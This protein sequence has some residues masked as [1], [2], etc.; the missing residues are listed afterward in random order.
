[1]ELTIAGLVAQGRSNREIAAELLLSGPTVQSYVSK[2]LVKLDARTRVDIAREALLHTESSN[3][4][5]PTP[6]A[7][8]PDD[9]HEFG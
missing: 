4:R 3:G 6:P 1:M 8:L 7:P 5:G 9:T 2:V